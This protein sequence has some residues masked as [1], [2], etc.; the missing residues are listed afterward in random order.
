MRQLIC[1]TDFLI[2][3]STIKHKTLQVIHKQIPIC[4]RNHKCGIASDLRSNGTD[5]GKQKILCAVSLSGIRIDS[6]LSHKPIERISPIESTT[7]FILKIQIKQTKTLCQPKIN[8]LFR[9]LFI[10]TKSPD[11]SHQAHLLVAGNMG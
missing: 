10:K 7:F 5:R 4:M 8:N 2:L 1:P 11:A 3:I 6:G 9:I